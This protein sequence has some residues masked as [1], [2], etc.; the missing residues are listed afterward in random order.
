[1]IQEWVIL[2]KL[3][4]FN[5]LL[6]YTSDD[7]TPSGNLYDINENGEILHQTLLH[8]LFNLRWYIQ[9]LI[10]ES[11]DEIENPLIEENW[12]KQ[13]NWK[14]IKYVIHNKHSGFYTTTENPNVMIRENHNTPSCEYI[15]IY[16]DELH[17]ASITTEEN[18]HTLQDKYK[19]NIYLHDKYP[20]DPGGTNICPIK[21]YLE[22]LYDN[23]K[24]LFN[25][26]LPQDLYISFNIIKL[27]IKKGNL[28]LI[29]NKNIYV[30]SI[31]Q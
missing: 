20:H 12:M 18:L 5:S 13:T 3:K 26:K 16:H 1:M 14:F 10:D 28:N 21:E 27:L 30:H 24:M 19:I 9:H 23:V 8:E 25:D 4:N 7:F 6:N 11:G 15:I 31:I 29:H 17:I 22:K 2:N